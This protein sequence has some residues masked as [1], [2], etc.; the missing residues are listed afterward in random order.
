MRWIIVVL[1]AI[2]IYASAA[3]LREHYRVG[4]SPCSI[5]DRW[6]CGIVNKSPYAM[7][8]G[9]PVADI[10]IGGYILLA[11][12]AVLKRFRLV[13]VAALVGLGFSLY[14]ANIEAHVLGVWCIYCVLSLVMIS[15]I[16]LSS[17]VAVSVQAFRHKR[18]AV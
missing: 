15:L 4:E 14:L 1:A 8:H 5:N 7:I 17:I 13:F 16:A 6:D 3:A 12:L 11:I 10:G 2:G 18:T 9:V